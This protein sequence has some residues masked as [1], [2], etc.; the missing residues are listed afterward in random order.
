M[1]IAALIVAA[2]RGTRAGAGELPKQYRMVRGRP[3]LAHS[4]GSFTSYPDIGPVQVAYN[5]ADRALY[6]R[7]TAQF[8]N[9]LLPPA[10]GGVDRQAS[11]LAGLEA[12]SAHAPTH[13]LIHDAAR[14]FLKPDLISRVLDSLTR[15]PGAIPAEPLTDSLKREGQGG[16]ISGNV[17][18]AGLWRAQTPQGFQF[19]AILDAHRRAAAAGQRSLTDD[20]AVAE[21]AGM[22]VALVQGSAENRKL[23]TQE[24]FLA[25][26]DAPAALPDIRTGS[27]IDVHRFTAGDHVM[28]C[29][30]RVPHEQGVE[31]HSDGDVGLHALTDALLG[32][33]GAGDIGQH[34]P[35]SN[36]K[37]RGA[38]SALFVTEAARLVR[39]QGGRIGN[40]D[41]T[42]LCER[43]RIGPFRQAMVERMAAILEISPDRVNLKATTTEKLGFTGRGEGLAAM[44]TVTVLLLSSPQTGAS[45]A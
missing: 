34:F 21:W 30:V 29:G 15:H 7:A 41:V 28:L 8:G 35:P 31:A 22:S 25:V 17:E 44:A 24:D 6:D 36:D 5:P 42:I 1:R 4:I 27:G 9:R 39:A 11:V 33:V 43:P 12:L 18:R 19:P 26:E 32:A 13:V 16:T 10:A 14:P 40:A 20:A 23:T 45:R 37:W 2:G 38:D 3:M